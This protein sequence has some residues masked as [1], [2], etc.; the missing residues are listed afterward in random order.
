MKKQIG[1]IISCAI[2]VVFT[3][4]LIGDD[5]IEKPIIAPLNPDFLEFIEKYENNQHER[6]SN[7]GR[8][9]DWAPSPIRLSHVRGVVDNMVRQN[10]PPAFDLRDNNKLTSVKDQ[11]RCGASWAFAAFS[12]LESYLKPSESKDFSEKNLI[13]NH[14]FDYGDCGYGGARMATAYLARWGGPISESDESY[15]YSSSDGKKSSIQKHIQQVVFLPERSGNLDND[16]IKYFVTNYGALYCKFRWDSNCYNYTNYSYYYKGNESTNHKVAIVGWDDNYSKYNFNSTPPG[17]GAFIVKDCLGTDWGENGYIYISYYDNSIVDFVSF[18]NAETSSNYQNI[19]L[20]DPLGWTNG[21]GYSGNTVAWGANVFTV[22]GSEI[23]KAVSFYTTD[24]NV[25]YDIHVYTG[26]SGNSPRNGTHRFSMSGEKEYPGY[27]TVRLDSPVS[28]TAG[29]RF[30]IVIKFQNSDYT[31]PVPVEMPNSNYSSAANANL[32]E[33][34]ISRNGDNWYDIASNGSGINICIKAFTDNVNG[35]GLPDKQPFGNFDTPSDGA[36]V[37]SSVAVTGWALDD[38]EV[39]SVRIYL[40]KNGNLTPIGDAT[41]IEG[42][43]PDIAQKYSNYPNNTRAGWGYML[44]TYFLPNGGNGRYTLCAIARDNTGHEFT[45]GEKEIRCDNGNATKPFGAIDSPQS[46]ETVSGT[47][48]VQGWTLTPPPSKIPTD[49]STIKIRVDGETVGRATYNLYRKDIAALF[50]GYANSDGAVAYYDLDTTKF[51]D[52]VHT[53]EWLV[54]DNAGNTDGVGSRYITIYNNPDNSVKPDGSAI[55]GLPGVIRAT[56]SPSSFKPTNKL[57]ISKVSNSNATEFSGYIEALF[58]VEHKLNYQVNI[59][60]GDSLSNNN[61][62]EVEFFLPDNFANL[63]GNDSQCHVYAKVYQDGGE[64]I[65]DMFEPF[66]T[67]YYPSQKTLKTKLPIYVFTN[68]R[69]Q[70]NA[71]RAILTVAISPKNETY[72]REFSQDENPVCPDG[73]FDWPLRPS[74]GAPEYVI[75]STFKAHESFRKKPHTGIDL[76]APQGTPIQSV[77]TGYVEAIGYDKSAGFYVIVAHEIKSGQNILKYKTTYIHLSDFSEEIRRIADLPEF[78]GTKDEIES[79]VPKRFNFKKGEIQLNSGTLI[80][81]SGGE[82][83]TAGAGGSQGPH[84]H[85]GYRDHNYNRFNP[86]SC[87][88]Q[89]IIE[90]KATVT[91]SDYGSKKDDSFRV[92]YILKNS[93]GEK[94]LGT[95]PTGG[96]KSFIFSVKQVDGNHTLLIYVVKNTSGKGTCEITLGYPLIFSDGKSTQK[97]YIDNQASF[98]FNV[99]EISFNYRLQWF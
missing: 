25:K 63:I 4:I 65:L 38:T 22:N 66:E 7:D 32:R 44:L 45:L 53:L 75:T 15:P 10:Y 37:R 47:I 51:K 95:S 72:T 77:A 6:F 61:S 21:Y 55:L 99:Q 84:L 88:D 64:E 39:E 69:K 57:S 5:G 78:T 36:I 59:N 26:V 34:Y 18:N 71:H 60:I 58:D 40:K 67:K 87:L 31:Y 97:C 83:G 76:R 49:G 43:R 19:Y 14:G 20:Y 89:S 91:V 82:A 42:A 70:D 86:S 73:G 17:D 74:E 41:F 48:R 13:S 98:L 54:T 68:K 3:I 16:T 46:G 92:C 94:C 56:F 62:F 93:A 79:S 30:S 35:G 80:G 33:S 29:D 28:L 23:L 11:G 90:Y 27:Y 1:I 50:P 8:P 2:L 85:M 9:L 52:G 96:S 12:S 24:S 81:L